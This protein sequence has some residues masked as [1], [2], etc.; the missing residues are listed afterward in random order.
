MPKNNLDHFIKV[1]TNSYSEN[2]KSISASIYGLEDVKAFTHYIVYRLK[3]AI[4]H[5]TISHISLR[6]VLNPDRKVPF[7]TENSTMLK[8]E[9][10]IKHKIQ[11]IQNKGYRTNSELVDVLLLKYSK[12]FQDWV[13]HVIELIC[14]IQ[15]EHSL[16]QKIMR[17]YKK[18]SKRSLT[19][20]SE[21]TFTKVGSNRVASTNEV[22]IYKKGDKTA[23]LK[24][25]SGDRDYFR[26]FITGVAN[27]IV[28]EVFGS[29]FIKEMGLNAPE[30]ELVG[31][32]GEV[33]KLAS[34]AIGDK[35][36]G[37][38]LGAPIRIKYL[39]E[40]DIEKVKSKAK[41][42]F[43]ANKK[44]K[45]DLLKLLAVNTLLGNNGAHLQNFICC[46][47]NNGI[48]CGSIDFER[49]L[50]DIHVMNDSYRNRFLPHEMW[51]EDAEILFGD[52]EDTKSEYKQAIQHII[53]HY[54]QNAPEILSH[55]LNN[56]VAAGASK[57]EISIISKNIASNLAAMKKFVAD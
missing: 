36:L 21:D 57:S 32:N 1:F 45:E 6:S 11:K 34:Y 28:R 25:N 50:H 48:K 51:H 29:T 14:I 44:A 54:E 31:E 46:K 35:T 22:S 38:V 47:S 15:T 20:Q 10:A 18:Q 42:L 40:S 27:P 26:A 55:S 24:V 30:V 3:E 13:S 8:L 17:L 37:E 9:A 52:D 53:K 33:E 16:Q 56:A 19:I 23:F 39:S 12:W 49:A 5:S 7:F 43:D 41:K 4:V 2:N